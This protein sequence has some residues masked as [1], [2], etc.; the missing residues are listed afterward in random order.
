M[1]LLD[2]FSARKRREAE[3]MNYLAGIASIEAVSDE[4]RAAS[5]FVRAFGVALGITVPE[6]ATRIL[7]AGQMQYAGATW[8]IGDAKI[9]DLASYISW[10]QTL[11]AFSEVEELAGSEA[12]AEKMRLTLMTTSGRMFPAS[13]RAMSVIHDYLDTL[14]DDEKVKALM[15]ERTFVDLEHRDLSLHFRAVAQLIQ[16]P[17]TINAVEPAKVYAAQRFLGLLLAEAT[18]YFKQ[19]AEGFSLSETTR[20]A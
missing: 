3:I 9:A 6:H 15:E 20:R 4:F 2:R 18:G 11:A 13:E 10:R 19:R 17:W 14:H 7:F 1:G 8:N 12:E 5:A 16:K